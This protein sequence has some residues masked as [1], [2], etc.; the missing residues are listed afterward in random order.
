MLYITPRSVKISH[1]FNGRSSRTQAGYF[2]TGSYG[3]GYFTIEIE[4]PPDKPILRNEIYGFLMGKKGKYESFDLVIAGVSDTKGFYRGTITY[5]GILN[6]VIQ[7][8]AE[9]NT[10][11]LYAGDYI[12]FDN[13]KKVYTVTQRVITN[14]LGQAELHI[15]PNLYLNPNLSSA[16]R[17]M[18]VPFHVVNNSFNVN[19]EYDSNNLA[20]MSLHFEEVFNA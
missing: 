11:I 17:Y 9:P 15:A 16:V 4:L 19:I 10:V 5:D 14:S 2:Y 1:A 18:D 7:L 3:G 12:K 13:H 8:L 6:N 20:E